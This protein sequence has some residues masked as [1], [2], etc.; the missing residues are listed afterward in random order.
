MAVTLTASLAFFLAAGCA[1]RKPHSRS[2][3][4][5]SGISP[6]E[7]PAPPPIFPHS[8]D[9]EGAAVH[10]SWVTQFGVSPCFKCHPV[11]EGNRVGGPPAC[12]TCHPLYPHD[13][14]WV[15]GEG[16]GQYVLQNGK[17]SCSTEC[18]GPDLQGG[19]SGAACSR[20]HA[21][22]PH[23]AGWAAAGQHGEAAEG[24]GKLVCR[25]C[26]GEDFRGGR[27]GVDCHKCH[28]NYPHGDEWRSPQQHGAFVSDNGQGSCKSGCHGPDLKGGLSGI[29]CTGCHE[30]YPHPSPWLEVH[31]ERSRTIGVSVCL[32]CHRRQA[33]E[34]I[35]TDCAS[36]HADY[37]HP[38]PAVWIPFASGH[39][40]RVENVYGGNLL[41][42]QLCH[43]NDLSR[44][45]EGKNCSSCHPSYPHRDGEGSDWK[46][47]EG[48]GRYALLH[49]KTECQ[50]C[51]GADYH[52]GD[53]G[54]P[55]CYSCHAVYPHRETWRQSRGEP[56]GH[57]LYVQSFTSASCATSRCHGTGLIPEAGITQGI[58]CS[59]CHQ[60][61]PH[62]PNWRAGLHGP[63]ARA[64]ISTCKSC[65]GAGL[66]K[67]PPGYPTCQ[68]CHPAYLRHR[69]ADT[70]FEGW[71]TYQG[72]GS[73]LMDPANERGLFEC[74]VCHGSDYSGGISNRSCLACH[75]SYPI[76]HD[77]E[78]WTTRE[79]HGNYVRVS[80]GNDKTN[81]KL[82]HGNDLAGGHS[83]QSCLT[84]CHANFPHEVIS[85]WSGSGHGI[86]ARTPGQRQGECAGCHGE[87]LLGGESEV[88]CLSCH[89]NFP[90]PSDAE[91]IETRMERVE[92]P[93]EEWDE[94]SEDELGRCWYDRLR[95]SPHAAQFLTQKDAGFPSS[96][97]N[98]SNCHGAD[99]AGGN[100]LQPCGSCHPAYPHLVF[101]D[102]RTDEG[103]THGTTFLAGPL[104]FQSSCT[105]CHVQ[106][107]SG[108]EGRATSCRGCHPDY[109]HLSPP[110]VPAAQ[111][112]LRGARHGFNFI[113]EEIGISSGSPNGCEGCHGGDFHGEGLAAADCSGCHQHFGAVSH[114]G[115]CRVSG[116]LGGD[117]KRP[118]RHGKVAIQA[119]LEGNPDRCHSCHPRLQYVGGRPRNARLPNTV[120]NPYRGE[121]PG[122][123]LNW[124]S[125]CHTLP[126]GGCPA[127]GC[128]ARE[129]DCLP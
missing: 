127:D 61:Y 2:P 47:F 120:C 58:A 95:M 39:G 72:H 104:D 128:V 13:A 85:G 31:G 34:R 28:E 9:W 83:G 53:R 71:E 26:H 124:C 116:R 19:L 4:G 102:W 80:L 97:N 16:H 87:D 68:S 65:H 25:S 1:E 46:D 123:A 101:P 86:Q 126:A 114:S 82:C 50:L 92:R 49:T 52:G 103:G 70:G 43:G 90:H 6:S 7:S 84:G 48:H 5:G 96:P 93:C 8:K 81:C 67:A 108:P 73:Y 88:S 129:G 41:S 32:N 40:A 77:Q 115:C 91:W 36:C 56:Q 23:P 45:F 66:D 17:V 119:R 30:V 107:G 18:H 11:E 100:A 15:R 89:A 94:G 64:D 106:F 14:S 55:S 75:P 99:Y 118:S 24:I 21:T 63:V 35:E 22:Y 10:G 76:L 125:G 59:S 42:C 51:H 12:R 38:D 3:E 79:G 117:W 57:G 113:M 110:D 121:F 33:G 29:S 54:N 109:P 62:P 122:S 44:R 112:W 27:G 78:N 111:D 69:S 98:C 60:A 20:C 105:R 74:Q 37:P